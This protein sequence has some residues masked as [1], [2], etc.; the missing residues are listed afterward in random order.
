MHCRDGDHVAIHH[1]TNKVHDKIWTHAHGRSCRSAVCRHEHGI[2]L[3][4]QYIGARGSSCKIFP[5]K[6]IIEHTSLGTTLDST[7]RNLINQ[8]ESGILILFFSERRHLNLNTAT[9]HI[10]DQ[11]SAR[12]HSQSCHSH[13]LSNV[14]RIES[15]HLQHM[16]TV[17]HS[18]SL[19]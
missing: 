14:K 10:F 11:R 9:H 1:N 7:G 13:H 5:H 18:R 12:H 6:R 8:P 2:L 17:Q 4:E 3:R 16:S 15:C 19:L